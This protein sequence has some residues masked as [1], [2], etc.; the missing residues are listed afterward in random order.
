MEGRTVTAQAVIAD[1]IARIKALDFSGNPPASLVR[2]LD[3]YQEL[4][5]V[6]PLAEVERA[7]EQ[8]AR[9]AQQMLAALR[10]PSS[11]A[12]RWRSRS[13]RPRKWRPVWGRFKK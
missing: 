1:M 3:D 11:R 9:N 7:I 6:H 2:V 12:G 4:A 5:D 8:A 10:L 13:H